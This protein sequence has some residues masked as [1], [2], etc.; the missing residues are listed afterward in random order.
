VADSYI[1]WDH[2]ELEQLLNTPD[3]PVGLMLED[4]AARATMAA[5]AAAPTQKPENYSWGRKRSTSYLPWSGGYTKARVVPHMGYTK[6]GV[7]F[8]GVNAPYA[9]TLFLEKPARQMHHRSA[10]MT[11][12]LYSINL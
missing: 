2:D 9:P 11:T 5:K 4:L 8:S 12:A 6:A 7:L 3:G 10:F 1:T